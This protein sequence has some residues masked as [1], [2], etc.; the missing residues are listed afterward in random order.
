MRTILQ[1]LMRYKTST[2]LNI[3]GLSIAFAAFILLAMQIRYELSYNKQYKDHERIYVPGMVIEKAHPNQYYIGRG[4]AE[5]LKKVPSIENIGVVQYHRPTTAKYN[6]GGTQHT[7]KC[8]LGLCDTTF[9]QVIE[10]DFIEGELNNFNGSDKAIISDV[11][12]KKLFGEQPALN[13]P[14]HISSWNKTFTVGGVY[15]SMNSGNAIDKDVFLNAWGANLTSVTGNYYAYIKIMPN[16]SRET[17]EQQAKIA[18]DD[19]W[20]T[21]MPDTPKE[22]LYGIGFA[23][24]AETASEIEYRSHIIIY[25]LMTIVFII[26]LVAFINFVNFAISMVPL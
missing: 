14:I 1:T 20:A 12:A 3:V 24:L 6:F 5:A 19:F 13:E 10:Y 25:I 21:S 9:F 2:I 4:L 7:A 11:Y 16:V 18:S 26:L 23:S 22:K 8:T 17:L 15:K